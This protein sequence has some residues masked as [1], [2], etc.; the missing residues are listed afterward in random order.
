MTISGIGGLFFRSR[1]PEARAAWYREHLGIHAGQD[2]MWEQDAGMTVFAPF[3]ANSDYF[4]AEQPFML[5]LRVTELD[6]LVDR[7][8]R[9]GIAVE[10]RPEWDTEYGRFV[11][12]HDPEGL[13]LELWE[14]PS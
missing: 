14:L 6:E 10:Q 1:D 3:P 5:N 12:I 13:P 8:E 4:D 11:R 7:L 2:G 9:A